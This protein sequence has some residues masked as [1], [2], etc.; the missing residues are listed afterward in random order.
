[1]TG[2]EPGYHTIPKCRGNLHKF[3]PKSVDL[4]PRSMKD[5]FTTAILPLHRIEARERY[6]NHL[7]R[8]RVGRLMEELDMFA[9]WICHRHMHIPNLPKGI[10]LPMLFV[11]LLFDRVDFDNINT[12]KA[13][14][15][16][17]ISGH[18][19]LVGSS[20][21]EITIYLLQNQHVMTKCIA[22][23]VARNATNTGPAVVNPLQP[24]GE[25]E[26]CLYK[27]ALERQKVRKRFRKRESEFNA[28]ASLSD[29]NQMYNLFQRIHGTDFVNDAESKPP[30]TRWMSESLQSTMLHP[31]PDNRNFHNTIFGGFIMRNAVEISYI[32]A[33][34]YAGAAPLIECI[35]DVRFFSPIKVH[36]FI[37]MTAY[38][39][40]TFE[41]Y[42]QLLTVVQVMDARTF[43]Q[44]TTNALNITMAVKEPVEEV[45]PSTYQETLWYMGGR[46]K[47]LQFRN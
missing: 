40:Y 2:V 21:L 4:P 31:F 9:V 37:K 36:S 25:A 35:L 34:I 8:V 13:N 20:S 41:R 3:Q 29:E 18:V 26:Q 39:V 11:T 1:S 30:N 38:V 5:S 23:M 45:L 6:V 27:E 12:V 24:N 33:S 44:V 46:N 7:G 47:F 16:I 32:T 28:R 22:V 43:Q 17:S 19:S 14:E 15:D 10:P 42:L